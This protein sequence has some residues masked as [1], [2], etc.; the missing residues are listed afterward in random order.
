MIDA[1]DR[2]TRNISTLHETM[3]TLSVDYLAAINQTITDIN[4]SPIELTQP[5]LSMSDATWV[6]QVKALITAKDRETSRYLEQK[7]LRMGLTIH[8]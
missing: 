3:T 1:C 8:G 2:A 6:D 5:Q 7:L 4:T